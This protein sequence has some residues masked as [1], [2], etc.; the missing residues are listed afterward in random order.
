M[1]SSSI[2]LST[3]NGEKYLACQID[4]ILAQTD[5]DWTLLIRD[6]GSSDGTCNIINQYVQSHPDKIKQIDSN[7]NVGVVRSFER[8]LQECDTDYI[9]FCD[10]DDFWLPNKIETSKRKM[11]DLEG[12]NPQK[13]IG[14][15]TDLK[16]VDEELQTIHP[17]FWEYSKIAPSLLTTFEDLCVHPAATGCTMMIN[18][19]AKECALPFC[20]E[21]RMHDSWIILSI[22]KSGGVIDYISSPTMLYRQ[23]RGN[24]IG[25]INENDS[26]LSHR[27]KGIKSVIK[28]NKAQWRMIK[29]L[30][31]SSHIHYLWL[32]I[33]YH[34]NY[35]RLQKKD[36]QK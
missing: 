5:S 20:E 8:L 7:K 13:A 12:K 11:M 33:K 29:K 9:F 19:L 1:A 14:I 24:V 25:A 21:V 27:I 3:Y 2:L 32:K 6:D 10:Q 4:S 23:H 22:L 18:R 16:V 28:S 26:Y 36:D 31:F 34:Y 15:Y 17:S 30:G 35:C